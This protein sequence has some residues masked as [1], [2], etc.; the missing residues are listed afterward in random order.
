MA[1][2]DILDLGTAEFLRTAEFLK[3]KDADQPAQKCR[4]SLM[5]RVLMTQLINSQSNLTQT[6]SVKFDLL[7]LHSI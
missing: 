2:F 5:Q 7:F 3:N 4:F 1:R 6:T